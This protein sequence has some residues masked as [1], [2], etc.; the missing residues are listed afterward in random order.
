ME[1]LISIIMPVYNAEKFLDRSISSVLTQTY[2][3]IQLILV[4]DGSPDNCPTLCDKYAAQ[5]KRIKVIHQKNQ[6]VSAARNT[7][8]DNVAGDYIM[9]VDSDDKIDEDMCAELMKYMLTKDV[10]IVSS[11]SYTVRNGMVKHSK[12][13]G[14]FS[15]KTHPAIIEYYLSDNDGVVWNK[16][17]KKTVIGQVRFP[18]G[19]LFEDCAALYKIVEQA[20]SIG[21]LDKE[22]YCYYKNPNSISHTSFDLQKRYEYYLAYKERY[23]YAVAHNLKCS[24]FCEGLYVKAALSAMTAGYANNVPKTNPHMQ[25]MINCVLKHRDESILQFMNLKYRIFARTCGKCDFIHKVGAKF[26][27]LAKTIKK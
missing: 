23:E 17:Y 12:R 27:L 4:E 5:D 9:F 10:D 6:G 11:P 1:P 21:Y 26:S 3:N 15:I 20:H 2:K 25:E 14:N 16:L 7:G 8:L 19:R 13:T 18:V 22:M 24:L